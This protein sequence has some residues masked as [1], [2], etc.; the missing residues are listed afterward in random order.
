[1]GWQAVTWSALRPS[2]CGRYELGVSNCVA[3]V[4]LGSKPIPTR[5]EGV[6]ADHLRFDP[7]AELHTAA[8]EVVDQ[9]SQSL[10]PDVAVEDWTA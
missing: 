2:R 9:R 1:M 7:E 8:Y 5:G 10:G 4:G 6:G 3:G